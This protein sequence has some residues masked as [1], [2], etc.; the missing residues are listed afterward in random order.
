MDL[1]RERPGDR[2][3]VRD[4]H[5]RAF[6]DHGRVVAALVDTLRGTITPETG[7]SLVAEHDGQIAGHVMFT[8]SLLDAPRRLVDVRVL[9]PLA[10]MPPLQKRGIGSALVQRGLATLAELTDRTP[11]PAASPGPARPTTPDSPHRTQRGSSSDHATIALTRCPLDPVC[12]KLRQLPSSQVRGHF[13]VHHPRHHQQPLGGSRLRRETVHQQ[14]S[15]ILRLR[16]QGA[17]LS[18]GLGT[19]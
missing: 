9:S 17:N 8:R 6:G 2:Q 19:T 15:A 3:A 11:R 5:L 13:P 10:V 12:W 1:R 7:L 16:R 18:D 14:F 4:L